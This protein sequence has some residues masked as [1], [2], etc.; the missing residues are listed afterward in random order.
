MTKEDIRKA[1]I[2]DR[3]F[4]ITWAMKVVIQYHN[5]V[6]VK[7]KFGIMAHEIKVFIEMFDPLVKMGLPFFWQE[8]GAMLS[9]KE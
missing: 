9:Q 5:L 8:N 1:G 4:V 3:I 7:A 2:R 6:T